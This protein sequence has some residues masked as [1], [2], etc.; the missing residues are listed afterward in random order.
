MLHRAR[1]LQRRLLEWYATAG[2]DLPWRRTWD[3]YAVLV[4]ELMLQQ[5]QVSRVQQAWPAFLVR[6]PTA[7]QLARASTADVVAAWRGLGYNRRA[8]SL[9]RAAQDVVSGHGG[10]VPADVAALERLPGVGPYTARAVAT[11][12]YDRPTAPVDTNVARV[13]SR[14]V[15]GAPLQG[16]A[17]QHLADT[18][19]PARQPAAWSHALMD[20]GARHC[21]ARA[22]GCERCPVATACAW[23]LG[24]RRRPDP[25]ASATVRPRAQTRF[26]GSDRYHRGRLV[27][28][29]R[30]GP[31]PDHGLAAAAALPGDPGRLERVVAGL[32]ADGLVEWR[33]GA[34]RLP[35]SGRQRGATPA[36]GRQGA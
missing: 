26:E 5:T 36:Q 17:G 9:Q 20:L 30:E 35:R 22:P 31:V 11:F 24:G 25:A 7:S 34:L 15:L 3:P 21:T 2:R 32:V 12:A 13:L 18:L 8:L 4:S 14:A 29:L 23:R 10:V 19:V 27:D 33:G 1:L 28:A 16:P 6:F